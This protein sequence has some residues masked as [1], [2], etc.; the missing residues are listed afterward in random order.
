MYRHARQRLVLRVE[1]HGQTGRSGLARQINGT[2]PRLVTNSAV[3]L[4]DA[5]ARLGFGV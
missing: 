2:C 3:A 1:N 5:M 4:F